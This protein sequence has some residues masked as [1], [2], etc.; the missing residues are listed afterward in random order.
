M[1]FLDGAEAAETWRAPAPGERELFGL[2]EA[3]AL[4]AAFFGPLL[5]D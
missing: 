4:G 3:V 2:D 1:V 5:A